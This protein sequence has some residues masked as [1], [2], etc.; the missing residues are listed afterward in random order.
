MKRIEMCIRQLEG[1]HGDRLL[2]R[3]QELSDAEPL[4]IAS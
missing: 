4:A 1:R 2:R 3:A